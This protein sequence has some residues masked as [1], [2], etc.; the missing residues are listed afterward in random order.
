MEQLTEA[1]L[2]K[3]VTVQATRLG[4]DVHVVIF[5]GDA[6]HMGGVAM[7]AP[8]LS[9]GTRPSAY[10]SSL[11]VPGH[12]DEVLWRELAKHLAVELDTTVVVCGGVHFEGLAQEDLPQVSQGIEALVRKAVHAL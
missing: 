9:A 10:L 8:Y 5:G 7:A 11:S 2:G 3:P 12:K 6:P 1:V 4:K